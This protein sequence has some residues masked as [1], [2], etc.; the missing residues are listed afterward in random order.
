MRASVRHREQRYREKLAE[1]RAIPRH[2]DATT[3]PTETPEQPATSGTG[4]S[5][6]F[7]IQVMTP[8]EPPEDRPNWVAGHRTALAIER[9]TR[10][11]NRTTAVA[12]G[13]R[14]SA[15]GT[16]RR[17]TREC[18]RVGESLGRQTRQRRLNCRA[19]ASFDLATDASRQEPAW[20]IAGG[21]RW[22]HRHRGGG[23]S[24]FARRRTSTRGRGLRWCC[25][26]SQPCSTP[27]FVHGLGGAP[28]RAG[29]ALAGW[30]TPGCC[31][32][33]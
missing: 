10:S 23:C 1:A 26:R 27:G 33:P 12:Y 18:V 2:T 21:G 17:S 7:H 9:T 24:S 11:G 6:G 22:L 30:A 14:H 32:R 29:C 5:P 28:A 25:S 31:W 16:P 8:S 4:Q 15:W 20:A 3:P 13:F 19:A